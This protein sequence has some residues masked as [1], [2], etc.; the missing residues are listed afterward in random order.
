MPYKNLEHDGYEEFTSFS[1]RQKVKENRVKRALKRI[2]KKDKLEKQQ[3]E[4]LATSPD[5]WEGELDD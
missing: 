5:V 2:S 3:E 4:Y 1:N